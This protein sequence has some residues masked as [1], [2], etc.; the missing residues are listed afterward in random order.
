M[1][2]GFFFTKT[3]F[4]PKLILGSNVLKG[5]MEPWFPNFLVLRTPKSFDR[6]INSHKPVQTSSSTVLDLHLG[7]Y[8]FTILEVKIEFLKIFINSF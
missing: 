3:F 1:E 5:S 7:R 8:V 4:S 2:I 6:D